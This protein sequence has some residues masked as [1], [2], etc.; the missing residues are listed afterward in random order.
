MVG[1][2]LR[3]NMIISIMMDESKEKISKEELKHF[4]N[5]VNIKM[6][7]NKS[8]NNVD[9]RIIGIKKMI[10]DIYYKQF[11]DVYREFKEV[12]SLFNKE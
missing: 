10:L 12:S 11:I 1:E 8:K 5:F 6:K 9:S 2:D 7:T 3:S 4:I